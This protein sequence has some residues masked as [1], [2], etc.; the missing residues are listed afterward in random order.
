[1]LPFRVLYHLFRLLSGINRKNQVSVKNSATD[2]KILKQK[3]QTVTVCHL[4]TQD[5]H[6]EETIWFRIEKTTIIEYGKEIIK[7]NE[8]MQTVKLNSKGPDVEALQ[9]LLNEWGY[10]V[11]TDGIFGQETDASVR[12][13]QQS[14][15]LTADGIVG[16]RTWLALEDRTAISLKGLCLKE[17]DFQEAADLLNVEIAAI[18]AVQ[19]VETGGKGGFIASGM[20][21]I[22]FEGH[23]FWNELKKRGINPEDHVLGNEDIL[24]PK[25]TK[26]FYKGGMGEYDRLNRAI[27]IHEEAANCSASWGMFQIMG[28]NYTPCG[29][30]TISQ[31]L[32]EMKKSEGTQL[33]LFV[34]FLR[35][36]DW[37]KYLRQHDW[38]EFARHYNGPSY[39]ENRYDEKLEHA[40]KKYL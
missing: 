28:F 26:D 18:K 31:F 7:Y 36:N 15:H 14:Q 5:K 19:E 2:R 3:E 32:I 4:A 22:L 6:R 40:Y 39:K 20:P 27:A 21:A 35:N 12:R 30:K 10:P 37:D 34:T 17:S 1:M 16:Q 9:K 24:Y 23:V 13:F 33:T 38:A 29:C 8:I 11:A 25:W